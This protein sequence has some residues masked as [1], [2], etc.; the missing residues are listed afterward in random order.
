[1]E[2][3]FVIA[4]IGVAIILLS[5]IWYFASYLNQLRAIMNTAGAVKGPDGKSIEHTN[6]SNNKV[7]AT[8]S[9]ITLTEAWNITT[10]P[11]IAIVGWVLGALM[12][13]GGGVWGVV[14]RSRA[15]PESRINYILAALASQPKTTPV[16]V[17]TTPVVVPASPSTGVTPEQLNA[18]REQLLKELTASK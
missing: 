14:Q 13:V 1:M 7:E 2:W 12:V 10:L 15:K 18:L 9:T 17:P 4:L 5:T 16:A 6:C 3:G 11:T 8:G